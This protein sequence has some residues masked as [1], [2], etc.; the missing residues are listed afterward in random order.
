MT[1]EESFDCAKV[2]L[3]LLQRFRYTTEGYG[4]KFRDGKPEQAET[5]RQFAARLLGYLDRWIETGETPKT[6]EGLRDLIVSEQFLKRCNTKLYIFLKERNCRTLGH[7]TTT[8]DHF[9]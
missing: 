6:Y 2:K 9:L 1:P 8:A 3:S 7:L 4:E 5:G